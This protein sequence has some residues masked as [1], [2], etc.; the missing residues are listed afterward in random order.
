MG[1]SVA[2]GFAQMAPSPAVAA[3]LLTGTTVPATTGAPVP[4]PV[5]GSV[6]ASAAAPA[7]APAQSNAAVEPMG[8]A[9]LSF[10]Y[11]HLGPV[12]A[13]FFAAMVTRELAVA[14]PALRRNLIN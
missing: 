3:A 10:D 11:T 5:T 13:S 2:A 6:V 7:P 4:P 14:V 12:G 9:K 8:D 1:P